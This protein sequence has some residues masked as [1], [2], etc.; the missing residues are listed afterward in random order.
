M[1]GSLSRLIIVVGP[2]LQADTYHQTG[3]QLVEGICGGMTLPDASNLLQLNIEPSHPASS[4][5][6]P[7]KVLLNLR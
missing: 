1:H 2:S 4:L 3:E 5:A 7:L 6:V